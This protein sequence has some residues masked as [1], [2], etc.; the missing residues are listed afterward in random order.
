MFNRNYLVL[1]VYN[2][3]LTGT[4]PV[5][6]IYNLY[7]PGTDPVLSIYNMYSPGTDLSYLYTIRILQELICLIYI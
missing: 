5:L 4:D 6:S 2:L 3:C 7:S 1:S